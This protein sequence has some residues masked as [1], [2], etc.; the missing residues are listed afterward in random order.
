MVPYASKEQ[1]T[2]IEI[3]YYKHPN[4]FIGITPQTNY[5]RGILGPDRQ[6]WRMSKSLIIGWMK[7][8]LIWD[9]IGLVEDN[10]LWK[11]KCNTCKTDLGIW[12]VDS[13]PINRANDHEKYRYNSINIFMSMVE[14]S[15]DTFVEGTME[16]FSKLIPPPCESMKESVSGSLILLLDVRNQ[17][18]L[19]N[20]LGV[21]GIRFFPSTSTQ[22]VLLF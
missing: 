8:N 12:K 16:Y 5:S 21:S 3:V 22:I 14:K 1:G 18:I 2:K 7:G 4:Y 20:I 9:Y 19:L 10:S 11:R 13:H 6:S 15:T 17:S